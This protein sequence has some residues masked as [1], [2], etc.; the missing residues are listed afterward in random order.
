[1]R[2]R[3]LIV[4]VRDRRKGKRYLTLKNVALA[5]LVCLLAFIAISIRSELGG[6]GPVDYGGHEVNLPPPPEPEPVEVVQEALSSMFV[7]EQIGEPL[8][9][10]PPLPPPTRVDTSVVHG[11][12]IAIVGGPEGVTIVHQERRRPTLSGGFGRPR[13]N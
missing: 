5:M 9:P 6:R 11:G 13:Q 7:D 10:P 3:D 2:R 8:P 4:P 12:E 1:M